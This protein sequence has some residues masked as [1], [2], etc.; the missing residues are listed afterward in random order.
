M[1]GRCLLPSSARYGPS[2][3]APVYS[4]ILKFPLQCIMLIR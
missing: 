4:I 3:A 2:R 1:R